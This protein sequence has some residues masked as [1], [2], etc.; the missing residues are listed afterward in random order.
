MVSRRLPP[1]SWVLDVGCGDGRLAAA[2]PQYRWCGVEPDPVLREAARARGVR[3]LPGC[4]EELPFPDGAFDAAC[5]FDVLEH[6][7]DDRAALA[8]ARR[9][10]KPGGLLF[11]SVPLHPELWSAH[12]SACGH[13]RR[14]RKGEA[15]G[16]AASLGFA[17][18]ERRYFVSLLLPLA[19]LARRLGRGGPDRLPGPLDRVAEE[20]LI[21]DAGLRLPFG[22]TEVVVCVRA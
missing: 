22:L 19:W 4:A 3:V 5:L 16:L 1:D 6:L 7:E 11:V 18:L 10:L 17:V 2:L 14:Y 9:V 21:L 13:F 20:V 15:A 8:E 12:D